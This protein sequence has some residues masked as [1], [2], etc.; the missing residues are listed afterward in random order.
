MLTGG[1]LTIPTGTAPGIAEFNDSVDLPLRYGRSVIRST[2][3]PQHHD[4]RCRW[5]DKTQWDA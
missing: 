2:M 1:V 3:P 4:V 5:T